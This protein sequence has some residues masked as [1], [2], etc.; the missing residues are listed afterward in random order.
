MRLVIGTKLVGIS[1][2]YAHPLCIYREKTAIDSGPV[3]SWRRRR[4]RV[5]G[6]RG[7]KEVGKGGV[8]GSSTASPS[9]PRVRNWL[10]SSQPALH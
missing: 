4:V 3:G 7:R 1:V 5:G 9:F 8:R 6:G 2:P 10:I